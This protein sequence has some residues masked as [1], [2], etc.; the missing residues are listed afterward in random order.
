MLQKEKAKPYNKHIN[1]ILYYIYV[2]NWPTINYFPSLY[3]ITNH[4]RELE[5]FY[6]I[7]FN[8]TT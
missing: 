6:Y 5:F 7:F 3:K 8:G 1:H 4:T 2:S